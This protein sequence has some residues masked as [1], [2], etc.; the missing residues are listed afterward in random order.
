MRRAPP[1]SLSKPGLRITIVFLVFQRRTFH[2]YQ[3]T[4]SDDNRR[5]SR[6]EYSW[7][8]YSR[9]PA[10]DRL[11]ADFWILPAKRRGEDAVYQPCIFVFCDWFGLGVREGG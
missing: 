10:E 6:R 1:V 8:F 5:L 9:S 4:C 7:L 3:E 2:E 11:P